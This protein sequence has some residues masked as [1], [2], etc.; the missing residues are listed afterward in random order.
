MSERE[1]A[2]LLAIIEKALGAS[3]L[4]VSDWL[5]SQ[6]SLDAIEER[7]IR[8]DVQGVVKEV[9]QA[10]RMFAA[11]THGA[12][13][14]AGKAG[15]KWLDAQP[16]LADKLV[17]FDVT[18]ARA[19]R[20]AQRNELEWVVGVTNDTRTMAHTAIIEGQRRNANPREVARDIREG[21]GLTAEQSRHVANYRRALESGDFANAMG[22]ELHDARSDRMLRRLAGEDGSLTPAQIDKMTEQYRRNYIAYRAETIART[23]SARNAHA[24]LDEAL[25]QAVERG[26]IDAESLVKEWIH[27]GRG[28]SRADHVAMD[29]K[30]VRFGEAFAMPDGARMKY[31]GDPAGGAANTANCRCTFATTIGA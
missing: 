21:L 9:E 19:I 14:T 26:E 29:G 31:P 24:G 4:D 13:T 8:G 3:W 27:A 25:T 5:R 20:A 17:R 28:R 7:L 16:A 23:E 2:K 15:A 22:R 6:N 12:F 18:N 10:A 1:M 11:E 30:T